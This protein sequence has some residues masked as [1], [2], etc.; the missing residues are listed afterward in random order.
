MDKSKD[1][2]YDNKI[3]LALNIINCNIFVECK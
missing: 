1:I 2:Q 3:F